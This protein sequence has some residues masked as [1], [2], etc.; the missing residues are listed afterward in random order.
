ML[1]LSLAFLVALISLGTSAAQEQHS[2]AQLQHNAR[3]LMVFAPDS[4]SV[5]FKAQLALIERHS[6]ELSARNTVVVPISTASRFGDE[7]FSFENL[8][9]GTPSAQADARSRYH[10]K[11]GDFVVILLSEDGTEEIRSARPVDIHELT[12]HLDAG[13]HR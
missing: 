3:V 1:K 7:R 10:V 6:F 2:L 4:D 11:D 8:P 13:P 5:S 9:L 12:A